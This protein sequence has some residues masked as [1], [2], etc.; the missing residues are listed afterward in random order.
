MKQ[1]PTINSLTNALSSLTIKDSTTPPKIGYCFDER[2]LLH[3]DFQNKHQECPERAMTVY[4]NIIDKGIA[5]QLHRV[6]PEEPKESDIL[7]V[8]T[9]EYLESIKALQFDSKGRPRSKN[10]TKK[11]LKEKDSYDTAYTYDAAMVAVGSLLATCKAILEN[12]LDHCFAIIRPPGHHASSSACKG[13]CIFNSVAIASEYLLKANPKLKLAIVDWDVHHGDGTQSIFYKTNNPLFISIHRHDNGKFYPYVTGFATETGEDQGKGFN[14]NIPLDT[15]S[16]IT[17][18]NST[19]GDGEYMMIFDKIVMPIL[20]EYSPDIILVSSGFDAGEGD[21]SGMLK[22]T[23][24]TYAY[25]TKRLMMTGKK[26]IFALEGGYTLDTLKR[27]SEAVFRTMLGEKKPFKD[28]MINGYKEIKNEEILDIDNLL[29]NYSQIFRP[30]NY[31]VEQMNNVIKIQSEYWKCFKSNET[32][33]SF[34]P[35]KESILRKDDIN[36]EILKQYQ[37]N[38]ISDE[39]DYMIFKIGKFL[40]ANYSNKDVLK[41]LK[42]KIK[43]I[44]SISNEFG[45]NIEGVRYTKLRSNATKQTKLLNWNRSDMK[46]DMNS[47]IMSEI[48]NLFFSHLGISSKEV[49]IQLDKFVEKIQSEINM[50]D[51]YNVDMIMI[52]KVIPPKEEEPSPNKKINKFKKKKKDDIKFEFYLN[53]LKEK[54]IKQYEKSEDNGMNFI[55]GLKCLRNFINE[56]VMN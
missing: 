30:I 21:I 39:C 12:K 9:K 32:V 23:P 6:F 52:P 24:M 46:Y 29:K 40:K 56:N 38:S 16:Q 2:M 26:V 27:C 18:G 5:N 28:V 44:R 35:K 11:T 31:C 36:I 3:K 1:D 7:S 48:F 34:T 45:F 25:M 47:I 50:Y 10:E 55:N 14:V 22:C 49:T 17:G 42:W 51:L 8:H 54:N 41:E 43:T 4:M 53:G 20:T 33:L 15:K 19:I 37:I 13:F